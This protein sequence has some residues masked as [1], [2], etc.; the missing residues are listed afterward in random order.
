MMRR[1]LIALFASARLRG[2]PRTQRSEWFPL[3]RKKY[4]RNLEPQLHVTMLLGSTKR[5]R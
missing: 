3:A 2:A 1:G 5:R 4:G